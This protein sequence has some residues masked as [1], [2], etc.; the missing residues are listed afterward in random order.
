LISAEPHPP[1]DRPPLSKALW[2]GRPVEDIWRGTAGRD[3]E[4]V[5]G[6]TATRLDLSQKR[7]LD[8]QGTIYTFDRLL[9]A[10]GGVP[11]RLPFGGESIV[12]FR[13]LDDY[14]RL[15]TMTAHG[16]RFAVIGGGFIGSEIA[17]ALTMNQKDVVML[18]PGEGIGAGL[19]PLGLAQFLTEYYRSK[20]VEV[21]PRER[22]VHVEARGHTSVLRTESGRLIEADGVVAGVGIVPN[23]DLAQAAGLQ[24]EDGVVVDELLRTSHPDVFAAGD[25]A[26]FYNPALGMH[27]RV[28]HEDNANTM[29][30]AAGRNMAGRSSPYHHLPFFYS[31]LFD[32]G[33]EAVGALDARL[34]MVEDWTEPHREGVVYYLRSGRVRGVL[35]WNVWDQVERAR[36][37]IADL[38]PFTTSDLIGRRG[39]NL[40]QPAL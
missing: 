18:F 34:T 28:E 8:D 24:V 35:L 5:L 6:R 17:A 32:L 29:G 40:R 22:V 12:Y 11:R 9:L 36:A 39:L 27:M 4:L 16:Q 38:G 15:R 13:S 33:Y 31:D 7:V 37:L 1:Y 19:F 25:A 26:R 14:Q 3:V 20:G 30:S 10:T 2:K 21:L 23:T